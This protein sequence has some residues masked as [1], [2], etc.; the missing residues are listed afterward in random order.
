MARACLHGCETR[1]LILWAMVAP[2]SVNYQASSGIMIALAPV[3][4]EQMKMQLSQDCNL[5]NGF[6]GLEKAERGN[7]QM[8]DLSLML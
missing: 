7:V 5:K 3:N 8:C 4:A 6:R 2:R 1:E